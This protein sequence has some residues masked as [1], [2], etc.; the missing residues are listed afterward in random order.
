MMHPDFVFLFENAAGKVVPVLV[1][2]HGAQL[3][4]SMPKLVGLARYAEEH[5]DAFARIYAVTDVD[6]GYVY[7]DMKSADV[8]E[9]VRIT[10][11]PKV[12]FASKHA[13]PYGK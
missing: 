7:L 13:K 8:R 4:D 12:I 9:V 2:P 6:G 10:D 5:G 3:S 11:D 1:D